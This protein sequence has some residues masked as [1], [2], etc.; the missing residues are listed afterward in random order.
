MEIDSTS[1]EVVNEIVEVTKPVIEKAM[2]KK[3]LE[4]METFENDP[5]LDVENVDVETH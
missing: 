4:K 1:I 2:G 5:V 3:D